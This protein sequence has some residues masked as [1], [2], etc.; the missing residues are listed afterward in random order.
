[1]YEKRKFDAFVSYNHAPFI[2]RIAHYIVHRLEHYRAPRISGLSKKKLHLCIDD[3][4]FATGGVLTE[5]INEALS[6]S[7]YLIY[8]ACEE[9]A[10]SNY[11]LEEVRTFKKLHDGKLDNIIVLLLNGTPETVFPQELLYEGL[12]INGET[13]DSDRARELHWL[14]LRGN[15]RFKIINFRRTLIKINNEL[16]MIAAPL[17][18]CDLE[19]LKQRDQQ[20]KRKKIIITTAIVSIIAILAFYAA[21]T[22]L[23]NK[24][25][26]YYIQAQNA[27]SDGNDNLALYYYGKTLSINP[28][29][30]Q[31]RISSQ[32]L[33]QN[34]IWPVFI[35]KDDYA[36]IIDDYVYLQDY[37]LDKDGIP[38]FEKQYIH[39]TT[40]GNYILWGEENDI[41]YVTDKDGRILETFSD[42]GGCI[43]YSHKVTDVWSFSSAQ[44]ECVTLYWPEAGQMETF[45][46]DDPVLGKWTAFENAALKPGI[47]AVIGDDSL[48]I[49][50][51]ENG[52]YTK[53]HS[54]A[55]S[56]LFHP[57][58]SAS[59]AAGA[60]VN[61]SSY[62]ISIFTSP[63]QSLFA[64]TAD[65][66]SNFNGRSDCW[67]SVAL[68][69][70][71][72]FNHITTIENQ[73]CLIYD[74][75]FQKDSQKLALIYNNEW[76]VLDNHGYSEI[77]DRSGNKLFS[78][79]ET[80]E[81]TPTK[82]FFCG[83][84]F[85]L[86]DLDTVYFLDAQTG[87]QLCEPLK[88]NI[89]DAAF[90]NDEQIAFEVLGGVEYYQL[91]QYSST[92]PLENLNEYNVTSPQQ[93]GQNKLALDNGLQIML[94]ETLNEVLLTDETGNILDSYMIGQD[95]ENIVISAEYGK[96]SHTIYVLDRSRN[97][98]CILIDY[99]LQQFVTD[100]DVIV[101]GGVL[102]F[103]PA[104][105][106]IVYLNGYY[107]EAYYST[108]SELLY[109]KNDTL[110]FYHDPAVKY[111]GWLTYPDINGNF[112]KLLSDESN[113]AIIFTLKDE[114]IYFRFFD[115][116]NGDWLADT[117]VP[118]AEDLAVTILNDDILYI[119]SN[120]EWNSW[121]LGDCFY[122]DKA[123]AKQLINLSGCSLSD[124]DKTAI[125]SD[126]WGNWSDFLT[127]KVIPFNT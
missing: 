24:S 103:A 100:E 53:Q 107:P 82:G 36:R 19:T 51:L 5:Q 32:I 81:I 67:C 96:S 95:E 117:S 83:N 16:P 127:W 47:Y 74:I 10:K 27:Q 63:D 61:P 35:K 13:P 89:H 108:V 73:D 28:F 90:V 78:T 12:D 84:T 1:M 92:S 55:W 94:S 15:S 25:T 114:Q 106:G 111:T 48:I 60:E 18:N 4:T 17:L 99:K 86:G 3:Q 40:S 21:H 49:Y 101:K 102:D 79:N 64:V 30:K 23:L 97:L 22:F 68:L 122:T 69:D 11:C 65:Y 54:I 26:D 33:L 123:A 38:T 50:Q 29:N 115:M 85:L 98:H 88:L 2:S 72:T 56:E 126:S 20:Y 118:Y 105:D 8:L 9:T 66:W 112:V 59:K 120:G 52:V 124:A 125:Y 41:Y 39:T 109:I 121:W 91:V 6:N 80:Y 37:Q 62:G 34:K 57:S 119:K 7:E 110:L 58:E 116:K 45:K 42:I 43:D 93:E 87:S 44:E 113:Y 31:A 46:W 71:D 104:K 75:V 76:A 70:S 77:Y 14:D